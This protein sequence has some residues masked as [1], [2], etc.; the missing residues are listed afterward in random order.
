MSKI[1]SSRSPG[2]R[3]L[4]IEWMEKLAAPAAYLEDIARHDGG[5]GYVVVVKNPPLPD[6][7]T[8]ARRDEGSLFVGFLLRPSMAPARG[9]MSAAIAAL[10]LARTIRR[11]STH[12][13]GIHWVSDIYA[14]KKKLAIASLRA[15]LKPTGSFRYLTVNLFLRITQSYAGS[16]P[17]V[18]QSIFSSQ[19][20]T[21]H[22]RVAE[23]LI[24][25]F[26]TLYEA[27]ATTDNPTFLEEYRELSLLQGKRIRYLRDGKRLRA[28]VFGIDDSARLIL[29]SRHGA[30]VILT[31]SSELYDK[32]KAK[33]AV[34]KEKHG[35]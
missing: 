27:F 3:L 16:L 9:G 24:N 12:E 34:K 13:P 11:H 25:E 20:E 4:T 1:T 30:S 23:T 29:T 35:S 15:A 32:R 10:A 18:V 31:S 22:E 5:D 17:E 2:G 14:G 19:R 33:I 28:T 6:S 26:F 21:L 8:A 7:I